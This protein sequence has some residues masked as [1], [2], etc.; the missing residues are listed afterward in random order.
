MHF[1][2]TVISHHDLMDI[3]TLI[4]PSFIWEIMTIM[5]VSMGCQR[6]Q[7]IVMTESMG[8]HHRQNHLN[9]TMVTLSKRPLVSSCKLLFFLFFL[10][11]CQRLFHE[12]LKGILWD[13]RWSPPSIRILSHSCW[14]FFLTEMHFYS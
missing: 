4:R 3:K 1:V 8:G 11:K 7:K 14:Y 6:C 9:V 13:C 10:L 12:L 2:S 5:E